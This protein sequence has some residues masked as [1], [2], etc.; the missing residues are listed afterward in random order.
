MSDPV[1]SCRIHAFSSGPVIRSDQRH[2]EIFAIPQLM[3][4]SS[5]VELVNIAGRLGIS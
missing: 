5:L 2:A 4:A 1:A 3:A